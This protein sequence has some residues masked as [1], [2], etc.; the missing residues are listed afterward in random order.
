MLATL[1]EKNSNTYFEDFATSLVPGKELTTGLFRMRDGPALHYTYTYEEMKFIVQGE[2]HLTD[3]TGQ[4]VVAKAGDLMYFP[5][6]TQIAFETPNEAL[7]CFTGQ[8]VPFV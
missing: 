4:Q 3:G 5:K 7:G 2:F 6:G 1:S 8:R